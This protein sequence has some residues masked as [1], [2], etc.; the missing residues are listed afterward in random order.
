VFAD[1][2]LRSIAE[3]D[4][5]GTFIVVSKMFNLS[6]VSCKTASNDSA[7]RD[8]SISFAEIESD[9]MELSEGIAIIFSSLDILNK[10]GDDTKRRKMFQFIFKSQLPVRVFRAHLANE[11]FML[12]ILIKVFKES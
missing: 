12:T 3:D 8:T 9:A 10:W 4:V 1:D 6:C 7:T 2:N 5:M 11:R